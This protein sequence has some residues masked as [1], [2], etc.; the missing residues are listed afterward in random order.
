MSLEALL[1]D[2]EAMEC[3]RLLVDRGFSPVQVYAA[4]KAPAPLPAEEQ[5]QVML[6]P[7]GSKTSFRCECGCNVF[8][9]FAKLR[10]RCNS[11]EATYTGGA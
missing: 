3:V 6:F 1:D 10:Y 2:P 7:G 5:E 9:R 8:T 4:M 11:C